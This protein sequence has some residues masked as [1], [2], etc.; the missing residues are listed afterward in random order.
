MK[1][2]IK[3]FIRIFIGDVGLNNESN[4]LQWLK[5]TLSKI[6]E[7][8]RILDAG[9]GTQQYRSL[10]THLNYVSQ[11]FGEYDGQGDKSGLQMGE[12]DYGNLDIVCDIINIPEPDETFDAILCTEVLEHIPSAEL[13]IK[14]FSRLLKK[15]GHL[16]LTAPFC[17][18]THFAPYHFSTGFNKYFYEHYL[19][20]YGLE[21]IEINKNGNLF[22]FLAQELI[23]LDY[24]AKKYSEIGLNFIEKISVFILLTALRRFREKDHE[25]S[26]LLCY[27]YHVLAIKKQN[28]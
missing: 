1:K 21:I 22:D 17:S 27:G 3:N 8:S 10:C 2:I 7:G 5:N 16:I 25:S 4:R 13:A 14:E 9:A 19:E 20:K 6:R 23:R 18:L 12:F 24:I 11:D 26:D 15:N 28:A